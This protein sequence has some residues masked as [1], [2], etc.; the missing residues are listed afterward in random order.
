M[1][2]NIR[3]LQ[4]SKFV[5]DIN[6]IDNKKRFI[7]TDSYLLKHV[8]N[9]LKNGFSPCIIIC[10]S[11][12]IGKS[13]IGVWICYLISKLFGKEFIPEENTFYEP[14]KAIRKIDKVTKECFL[15]DEA[16]DILDAREWYK[17]T[18]QAL[19]S[20][21]NT[22]AYKTMLYIFV[23][24]FVVDIDKSLRK[25][26]DFL[27]RV[28]SR[29]RFKTFRYVKKYDEHNSNYVIRRRFLDD[30]GITMGLIPQPLWNKYQ[31]FSIREKEKIRS[32][33]ADDID[34][35]KKK[36]ETFRDKWL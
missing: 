20:I 30:M 23:S 3:L 12:R 25:H 8:V 15:I 29:G 17:Q 31:A 26:F 2:T 1:L 22:Q 13:F 32:K 35:E 10:G 19:R 4:Q 28:D 6:G 36:E 18:H 24:P 34:I 5:I 7:E 11:Q 16:G 9:K 27:I 21:I 33:R 14:L